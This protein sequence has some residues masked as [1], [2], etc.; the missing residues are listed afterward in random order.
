MNA[1][2]LLSFGWAWPPRFLKSMRSTPSQVSAWPHWLGVKGQVFLFGIDWEFT[3]FT[4]SKN[5]ELQAQRKAG[6]RFYAM[7]PFEDVIGFVRALPT[8]KGKKYAAAL[9]L[10]DK[11]SQ[12]GIEVFSF[13][14]K[15]DLYSFIA[16]NES[17]PVPG[18]DYIGTK[19]NVWQ[20]GE[21]FANLQEQQAIRYLG[22]S[23]IFAMEEHLTVE[24]AFSNPPASALVKPIFNLPLLQALAAVLLTVF[25]L[26][27]AANEYLTQLR[28]KEEQQ[29]QAALNDPNRLYEQAIEPALKQ[30]SVGGRWQLDQWLNTMG[31]LPMKTAGWRL[32]SVKCGL[33]D[34]TATWHREYGNFTELFNSLPVAF[35]SRTENMDAAKP[36][37]STATTV[38]AL[39][40]TPSVG[41]LS[42]NQLPLARDVL[43]EF[44][45]QLQDLSLLDKTV[46]TLEKPSLFPS[47]AQGTPESLTRPVM[48]GTWGLQLELWSIS[49][50][51]LY[52]Y[53]VPE[54]LDLQFP[55]GQQDQAVYSLKG[56]FYALYK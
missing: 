17:K 25:G 10:A 20:L 51:N 47:A 46:L 13:H 54:S 16:L 55:V 15:D 36:E 44:S 7:S 2:Q 9:H 24:K 14:L 5:K 19:E 40:P 37:L 12:G 32:G 49:S 34:C 39:S 1:K 35:T 21:D 33:N 8:A 56:S 18:H 45:S 3:L 4:G 30:V 26:L 27:Y 31:K 23:G 52:P 29:R 38:H 41:K 43:S 6:F 42:R 53:V 48:R 28:I 22:N 11:L 50:L